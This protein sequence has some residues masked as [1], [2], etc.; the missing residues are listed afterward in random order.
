MIKLN[1]SKP[2]FRIVFGLTSTILGIVSLLSAANG[3]GYSNGF[4]DGEDLGNWEAKKF[5]QE[6]WEP[7]KN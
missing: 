1:E 6:F 2:T 7:R 5:Y 3:I 4:K